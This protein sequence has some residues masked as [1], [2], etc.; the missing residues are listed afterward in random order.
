MSHSEFDQ[1]SPSYEELLRDPIRE[2]FAAGD[3]AFFHQ[4][5]SNLIREYFSR[6]NISTRNLS[7][8]DIGCGKGE[9]LKLLRDDFQH[10]A[11][12]DPSAGMLSALEG[13]DA[14]V[15]REPSRLPFDNEAFDFVTAVCV[16][17]HVLPA[18]RLSLTAEVARILKPGGTFAIIEHNP[19][20]PVT[21]LIVSRTPVDAD[22]ILL[23]NREAMQWMRR[24]GF[25]VELSKY[26]L[27]FPEP[28]YRLGGRVA[29][30]LLSGIPMGGQYAVFATKQQPVR[31]P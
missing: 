11:G 12:S 23:K 3:S 28:L 13:I 7:Y 10:V 14:R 22:A 1:Y 18:D 15:Q 9:L 19:Y 6:R 29:E 5:K 31:V 20:N 2:R 25:V 8:L 17:H 21:R 24:A 30:H 26:F 27:Y 4:R 16:Y